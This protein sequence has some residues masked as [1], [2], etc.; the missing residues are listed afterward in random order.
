[1]LPNFLT[2]KHERPMFDI[3]L[4]PEGLR[5]GLWEICM[6]AYEIPSLTF[7]KLGRPPIILDI[8]GHVGHFTWWAQQRWPGAKVIAYEPHPHNARRFRD[9]CPDVELHEVA[10]INARGEPYSEVTLFDGNNEL[11][12][13]SGQAS[14][15]CRGGQRADQTFTVKALDASELPSCDFLKIDTEGSE[16]PILY[17]YQHLAGVAAV[18]MEW[19][20]WADQF[21]LGAHLAYNEFFCVGQEVVDPND[22]VGKYMGILKFVRQKFREQCRECRTEDGRR[23]GYRMANGMFGC[24]ECEDTFA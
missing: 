5:A 15:D 12:E 13:A 20:H 4:A 6:G 11:G 24:I 14:L 1:M 3:E 18:A 17:G 10:V 9:N 7:E 22:P 2:T 8:G 23:K 21:Y 19:H 16:L